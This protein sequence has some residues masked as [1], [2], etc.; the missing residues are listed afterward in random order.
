VLEPAFL[1]DDAYITLASAQALWRGHDGYFIGTPAFFGITSPF[2]CLLVAG[3]LAVV[4]PLWALLLSSVLGAACYAA[5]VWRLGESAG[6]GR[7]LQLALLIAGLGPGMVSQHMVNGLETSWAMAAVT[8][9]LWAS[10]TGRTR[11]LASLAGT[12]PFVRPEL[13]VLSLALLALAVY[14]HP[15]ERRGLMA[16]SALAATPWIVLLAWQ[17]GT[18]IPTTLA[19]KR[20]WYAEGC[21]PAS[22]RAQVLSEGIVGWLLPMPVVALGVFG[23]FKTWLGRLALATSAVI[24]TVWAWSVPNVLHA[25][26][27]HRYYAIFLPMLLFGLTQLPR[28]CR[29]VVV[30]LAATMAGISTASV[31]RFE[32]GAIG[33][34]MGVRA[35]VVEA[36]RVR[37]ASRV[38]LHDAG[39][40]A[41]TRAGF[42]GVDM[43]GLKT[44]EAARLHAAL[45]GPTCGAA[46]SDALRRLARATRPSHLVL[47]APW[48]EYFGV[49]EALR[50]GG[51]S[52]ERVSTVPAPEPIYV[53]A[54]VPKGDMSSG[55]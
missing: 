12:A 53:Y 43:V 17:T 55:Q 26:Q 33:S 28:W 40:L 3:L 39:Y 38:L 13:G 25:Y 10:H 18:V 27:R 24:L 42:A 47:W 16:A 9:M 7:P 41:Y 6:I 32:P 5:G 2:H 37:G 23:V 46:R 48:D 44:P 30:A 35:G 19:A 49:T 20:D 34:A 36:L 54:L 1:Y 4:P 50:A 11:T 21:W 45:T 51:W 14:Q 15:A 31:V 52:V 29:P 22:R 8:W